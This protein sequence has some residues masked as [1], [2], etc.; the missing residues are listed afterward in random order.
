MVR[1]DNRA[2]SR[3]LTGYFTGSTR[4]GTG[5][6]YVFEF[7]FSPAYPRFVTS[8]AIPL[9]VYIAANL[10]NYDSL[11]R[12]YHGSAD[13]V[14]SVSR[15]AA[16]GHANLALGVCH[17]TRY[18]SQSDAGLSTVDYQLIVTKEALIEFCERISDAP[19]CA[20]DT[21]FVREKTYY[22]LLSLIQLATEQ[23]MACIDPLAIRDLSP[24]A[25]LME[26][27]DLL[28]IF[29]SPSQDLEILFQQFGAVP[30]PVFD[31]QLAAAVLGF[32]HQISYADLV[33]EVT[34]V[35]LEKKHTRADWS[36]RPLSDDELD[37]AMDD[38]RYLLPVYRQLNQSL[39]ER[40]RRSWIEQ[41]LA[42]MS[43]ASNYQI[44]FD[45]LWQKLK[46]VQK[47]KGV[48]LQI[49]RDFCE[50][51][52]KIAQQ[53]NRPRRWIVADDWII[54]IARRKPTDLEAL[55]SI[56]GIS[57]K[58]LDRNARSWLQ[59]IEQALQ[60]DPS[61]WPIPQKPKILDV[62]QQALGD[63]LMALCRVI[64]DENDIALA[65]L[66]TRKD[67][68]SLILNRKTS[69]LAQGWHFEMAGQQLL[70]FIHA[71]S[72]LGVDQGEIRSFSRYDTE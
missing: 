52:E 48:E 58:V 32:T 54:D 68:D 1:I 44:N 61:E 45:D 10:S 37:Y 25:R 20:I 35:Q 55:A 15:G 57:D 50:W 23:H 28:K 59:M 3:Y 12:R 69:R 17:I 13:I 71:Q 60:T 27:P 2:T 38:V 34:S 4:A 31:T 70:D 8:T 72:W 41:D 26:K 49:A 39:E 18:S 65:T 21:E 56:R 5:H 7:K 22:P 11:G 53:K 46:A 47:L 30:T 6:N 63:C 66:A 19:Y 62:Q 64:A 42:D 33:F 9:R 14:G 40:H 43:N 16:R 24:L 36:R 67:I 29:H 51:R